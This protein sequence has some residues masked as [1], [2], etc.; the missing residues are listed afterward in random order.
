[1][2]AIFRF[3]KTRNRT[4]DPSI[5]REYLFDRL[6]ARGEPSW[7]NRNGNAF[8]LLQEGEGYAL[9]IYANDQKLVQIVNLTIEF[10]GFTIDPDDP[11]EKGRV[12]RNPD[13]PVAT[14]HR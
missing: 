9:T 5:L 7:L 3:S 12:R 14:H 13:K 10:F 1:M 8:L 2:S 6:V 11:D 4:I